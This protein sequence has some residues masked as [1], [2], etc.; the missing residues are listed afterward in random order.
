MNDISIRVLDAL[1]DVCEGEGYTILEK[2]ELTSHFSNYDFAPDELIEILQSLSVAG[3]IDLKYADTQEFCVAMKTKGRSFIKQSRE[4]LQQL[5]E[6]NSETL[7]YDN[8]ILQEMEDPEEE[9]APQVRPAPEEEGF[10]FEV[11]PE[12]Q[13]EKKQNHHKERPA[14]ETDIYDYYERNPRAGSSPNLARGYAVQASMEAAEDKSKRRERKMILA[15]CLG[16]AAGS[17]L[18][19]LVFL[20]VFLLKFAGKG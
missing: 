17:L 9:V 16:A 10:S 19:D 14:K 13:P 12:A 8:A 3:F 20:I 11:E 4:K 6:T 1:F 15:A 2:G 7:Q 18:M 5:T